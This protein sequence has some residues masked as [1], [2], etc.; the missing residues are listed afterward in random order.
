M[1]KSINT[2]FK[3]QNETKRNE[4]DGNVVALCRP[5]YNYFQCA[6]YRF[7]QMNDDDDD[8]G[9]DERCKNVKWY[10]CKM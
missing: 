3:S 1:N 9:D 10:E 8:N 7:D 5:Y 4:M 2:D 6:R